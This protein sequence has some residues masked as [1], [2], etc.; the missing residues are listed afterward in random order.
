MSSWNIPL[1]DLDYGPEEE[2]AV[3][4]VLRSKWLSMGPEV[5]A[6]EGEF[7][8]MVGA[9]HAYAVSSATA[10]LHLALLGL[11]LGT[12][13]EIIQPA[14]NF[15]A[16]ANMTVATGAT[17]VFADICSLAEPTIDPERVARLIT[18]RT[19]AVVVM[20]YGGYLGRMTELQELCQKHG[21]ALIEDACHAVGATYR[22]PNQRGPHGLK[23][24]NIGDIS[25]FSF[26]SNKNIATGEGGMVTTNRDDVVE[27]LRLLRSHGMTSLTWDRHKGHASSYE[28]VVHG[29]NYR[30]DE[31]HAAL[32]RSQLA[33]LAQN[34]ARRKMVA[35]AYHHKL[36][37]LP[38]WILP[39]AGST[40]DS[41]HHLMVAVAP[42]RQAREAM[43]THLREAGIQT[44]L[45]YPCIVDFGAFAS[46]RSDELTYSREFCH[47]VMTLPLYP[48][49]S[50]GQV[51]IVCDRIL[52]R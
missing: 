38:G 9:K 36:R 16:T 2:A 25:A 30:L 48:S 47:R 49:L 19:K 28:V 21:L 46:A 22:D 44:S 3:L 41:A 35:A 8:N 15:V 34:N 18:P 26:F 40:A 10:G 52:N 51:S 31:L 33:K 12:G 24:G 6:F 32:G 39:Y 20:H 29:Y 43:A 50:E 7:A 13:D 37:G 23:A 5:Q 17:P 27:R 4:R 42:D 45:H 14:V 1:S 11:G